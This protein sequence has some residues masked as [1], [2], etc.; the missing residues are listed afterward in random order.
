MCGRL[1]RPPAPRPRAPLPVGFQITI[2]G[3]AEIILEKDVNV[4]ARYG[5]VKGVIKKLKADAEKGLRIEA[6][7]SARLAARGAR[8]RRALSYPPPPPSD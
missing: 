4:L 7:R 8:L 3:L 2:D 6:V 5:G 1:T